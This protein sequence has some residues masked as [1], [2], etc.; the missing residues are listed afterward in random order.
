[1]TYGE[2]VFICK[3]LLKIIS[4][5]AT[6]EDEHVM[7][8]ASKLRSL[9][10]KK[11][12]DTPKK[13]TPDSLYQ[14]ICLDLVYNDNS[15]ICG[16]GDYLVS[17]QEVPYTMSI[18]NNKVYPVNYFLG[19]IEFISRERFKYIKNN[20]Y[21]KNIIFATLGPDGHLYLKS[22]NNQFLA[23]EKVKMTAV[24]E[25]I[26]KIKHLLCKDDG[27]ECTNIMEE[28]FPIE[29]ALIPE[30]IEMTVKELATGIYHPADTK[31][32]AKD[33]L[34]DIMQFI[35]QNM[36]DRYLKDYGG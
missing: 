8:I 7:F 27:C 11:Y 35:R 9:L 34:S 26:S 28:D 6:F 23:L 22:A 16:A 1:M 4:D 20:R 17:A 14:T 30:L 3:D 25:D 10:I 24:F 29:D 2:L 15:D 36:K 32:N 31:N 33:D 18:G 19:N 12:Y 21:I 5:D 13:P